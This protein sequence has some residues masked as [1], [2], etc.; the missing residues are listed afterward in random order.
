MNGD[1]LKAA[2]EAATARFLEIAAL[3]DLKAH[4][5]APQTV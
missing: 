3:F 2:R 5:D 4:R 1:E